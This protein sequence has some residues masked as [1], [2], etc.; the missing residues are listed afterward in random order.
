MRSSEYIHQLGK[1]IPFESA[2][3]TIYPCIS[4]GNEISIYQQ[5]SSI[6][7]NHVDFKISLEIEIEKQYIEQIN[8][9][10]FF[11]KKAIAVIDTEAVSWYLR[12]TD[13]F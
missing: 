2:S 5:T 8:Y 1:R 10:G 12:C 6:M 4:N 9:V 11:R 13:N 3:Y 7:Q